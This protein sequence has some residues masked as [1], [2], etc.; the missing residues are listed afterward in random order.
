MKVLRRKYFASPS[1]KLD[2]NSSRGVSID[3][4]GDWG[5]SENPSSSAADTSPTTMLNTG[6]M[7]RS[8]RV[9]GMEMNRLKQ[10]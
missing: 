9:T 4:G 6:L 1:P 10:L 7:T 5:D 8:N 2:N 3:T